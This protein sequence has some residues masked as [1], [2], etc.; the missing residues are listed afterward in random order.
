VCTIVGKETGGKIVG[1][2]GY[3]VV[4][5]NGVRKGNVTDVGIVT[6][7]IRTS[8]DDVQESANVTVKSAYIGVTGAHVGYENRRVTLDQVGAQ[9]VITSEDISKVPAAAAPNAS[10]GDRHILHALPINYSL[11]GRDGIKNP[12]GMHT[13][14]MEVDTHIVTA[15]Q[16]F[17]DKLVE[18]VE[19]AGITV[20]GLVLEPLASSEAV[21]TASERRQG[22]IVIDIGGGTTDVVGYE[23]NCLRY[24][25]V[26]PVGGYQFTNDISQTYQTSYSAA[27]SIKLAYANTE[28]QIVGLEEEVTLSVS[29]SDAKVQVPRRD[30]CQLTRERAQELAQL[31]RLKVREAY[32]DCKS[33]TSVIVTGGGSKL[34]GLCELIQ[35]S[36]NHENVRLGAPNGYWGLPDELKA[37]PYS[38][39]VGMLLWAAS[40]YSSPYINNGSIHSSNQ[41]RFVSRVLKPVLNFVSTGNTLTPNH[42]G[43]TNVS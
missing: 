1:I 23:D 25:A 13:T 42:N 12:V 26:I 36:L 22:A 32:P 4:T 10:E 28:P 9:G 43:G 35:R 29:N 37:P 6:K 39:G 40:T 17:I 41:D 16:S 15:E 34:D 30:I 33:K 14:N 24:T 7:A 18:A 38:T 8:L 3:S 20:A 21:L 31:I 19:A 2:A 5:C 27:E 11:D